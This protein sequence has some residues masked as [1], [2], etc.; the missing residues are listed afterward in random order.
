MNAPRIVAFVMAGGEG[1][2]LRPLTD[3]IPKPALPFADRCRLIDFVLSNLHNSGIRSTFVLLQYKPRALVEHLASNWA[4]ANLEPGE[5]IE[6][7]LPATSFKGT[8]DAVRQ[9][10]DRIEGLEPDLVAVFAADHVYRMDVRAMAAFHRACDADATV[11]A[12]PVPIEQ[13]CEFGLVRADAHARIRGFVE[14]PAVPTPAP[15]DASCAFVSMGNYLFRPGALRAALRAAAQQDEHDFGHHVLPRLVREGRV[16]A[17]D[18]RRNRI[19]GLS[20]CEE[21]GY[22]RDVGTVAAYREAERDVLGPQPRLALDNPAWPIRCVGTA[23]SGH[24]LAA[25]EAPV[26][27]L[28]PA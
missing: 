25:S 2:R 7:V 21:P 4:G 10:L 20:A 24:P 6:P 5:F 15:D 26:E 23:S 17:Y 13:A 12:L 11:A 16:F 14:K 8:A 19:P 3:E 9:S 22:W 18:F 28:M 1:R 27:P